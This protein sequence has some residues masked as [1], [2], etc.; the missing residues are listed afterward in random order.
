MHL[1]YQA[2]TRAGNL[3]VM[4]PPE[5]LDQSI[6]A[7][8]ALRSLT[9]NAARAGGEQ[10][11]KGSLTPGKLAD[12]V[13]LS[14]D[15]LAVSTPEIN[16]IRVLL[17]MIDGRI[18]WCAPDAAAMCAG[19]R[20]VDAT[21][22]PAA[23]GTAAPPGTAGVDV[24]ASASLPGEP[25]Q[26]AVDGD[27]ETSWISGA[28]AEQWIQLDLGQAI[29]VATIRLIVAQ[30]PAGETVHEL[31]VGTSEDDLVHVHVIEGTTADGDVLEFVAPDE[32]GP[33]RVV[34]VV[35]TKSP[36]WVAWREIEVVPRL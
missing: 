8:E 17:T 26:H 32:L 24:I 23:T 30:Y 21:P 33:I 12:L 36:S 19:T 18:E 11:E 7:E 35:T 1:T 28:D 20:G 27:P 6:T 10:A 13:V 29:T 22:R 2:V 15:P 34:R 9:I 3:G 14:A 5:L 25:A 31:W 16:D 4:S